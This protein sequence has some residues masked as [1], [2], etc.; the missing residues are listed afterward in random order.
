MDLK[1][2]YGENADLNACNKR[3]N[4]LKDVFI[5]NEKVTPDF[6]FSSSGRAEILGNHTDHNHGLVVVA[7]I[8]CD[9]LA[10]VLKTND[11]I[12]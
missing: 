11:S 12:V 6:L 4:D 8:S 1:T 7:S 5:K 10:W 9:V 3:I 2:L